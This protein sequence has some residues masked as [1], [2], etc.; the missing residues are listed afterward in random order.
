MILQA[1][2]SYYE[3]LVKLGKISSPGWG[4]AK[5]SYALVIDTEGKL[6]DV[7]STKTEQSKGEKTVLA[8]QIMRVPAPVKR[9]VGVVS[10]FLCDHSG[11]MLGIDS[12][13]NPKRTSDCFEACKRKHLEILQDT[14]E[15]AA[16]A[17]KEFFNTWD[18]EGAANNPVLS[19]CWD[20]IVSGENLVFCFEGTYIQENHSIGQLWERYYMANADGP[21]MTCLI[22]GRKGPVEKTHPAIKGIKGAQSSGAA[23]IS[24]NAPAFCSYGKE[25]N[26]NAPVSQYAAFAYTTALNY[27]IADKKH[28]HYMGDTAVLCWAEGGESAYQ[29]FASQCLFGVTES[30]SEKDIMDKAKKLAMGK[31]VEFNESRLD[32]LNSFYFLGIA[33]NAARLSVRF[34]YKDSFGTLLKNINEHYQRMEIERPQN[35]KFQSMPLWQMLY[36]T[37]NTN[38]RNKEPSP[39]MAGEVMR[40]ILTN[41]AYPATLLNG[42]TL[43]IRADH[44]VSPGRAAII[45]GFYLKNR[46]PFVP[47]EVLQVALNKE[48]TNVPYNLGRLF[49]ILENIQSA[50][51]PGI[52]TTIKDR[53]FNSASAT[54]GQVFPV[55][56]NLSQKHLSKIGGGLQVTLNRDL[57][58]ILDKLGENFPARLNL[59]QQ[60]SFQLGYYHQ[61]QQRFQGKKEEQ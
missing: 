58:E 2:T 47:E 15:P 23:L 20:D 6:T 41:T 39:V 11:Y 56:I 19:E 42:V 61:R 26:Y 9:S 43:R 52:N 28:L 40:S 35:D 7:I 27:L 36:E 5:V 34:F 30:Y 54:P 32:P 16:L 17:L 45:K 12:K 8:P 53:Y 4:E 38:S 55:L 37:V 50:A 57:S 60:G 18:P 48:S 51:N 33:P 10:N 46:S 49:A 44:N 13:G 22:T 21:E 59:Q 3:D 14:D 1:L 24:F 31:T 25:Q 29:G